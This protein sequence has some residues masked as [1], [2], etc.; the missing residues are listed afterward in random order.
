MKYYT[1]PQIW[2]EW[3]DSSVSAHGWLLW[4]RQWTFGFY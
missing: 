3:L 1:R 4:T 2:S